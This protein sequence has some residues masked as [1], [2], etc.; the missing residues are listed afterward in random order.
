MSVVR[1]FGLNGKSIYTNVCKPMLVNLNFVVDSTNGNG[2]GIRSLKSN[3]YVENVFMHTSATPGSNNG[4]LNPNPAVG[5]ALVQMKQNFNKFLSLSAGF[6]T[7]TATATKVDNSA[8]T[9]GQV[10]VISTLGNTTAAQWLTLG[11]PAGVT[12]AV[13]VAFTA[14]L[15]GVAG[16]A[17]TSTSRVMLPT[18]SGIPLIEVVGDTN[19]MTTANVA[20]N[21]GQ[22]I[23]VQFSAATA[24]GTTTLIP[25]APAAG[26]VCGM[27]LWFDGS[28]VTIDGI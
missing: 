22:W 25:T 21:S 8:L 3:G 19:L 13:G 15:V 24:A 20:S 26:S 6:V 5:F 10:Y 27:Q 7:P 18:T 12:P 14:L 23:T 4:F 1:G 17:N 28:S 9:V 16:E 2:L 11:V